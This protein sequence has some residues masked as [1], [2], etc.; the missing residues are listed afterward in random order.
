MEKAR[1]LTG[2]IAWAISRRSLSYCSA[3][4]CPDFTFCD[5]LAPTPI[6]ALQMQ[7]TP[8]PGP[9]FGCPYPTIYTRGHPVPSLAATFNPGLRCCLGIRP[10]PYAQSASRSD[11]RRLVG[12]WQPIVTGVH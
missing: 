2:K 10:E 7:N 4:L 11:R 6:L 3:R 1:G 8:F 9:Y 12:K 5:F